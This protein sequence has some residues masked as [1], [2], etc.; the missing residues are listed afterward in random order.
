MK[1][2]NK[3]HM[4]RANNLIKHSWQIIHIQKPGFARKPQVAIFGMHM[5][6]Y[7]GTFLKTWHYYQFRMLHCM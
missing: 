2:T 6:L 7:K 3:F 4:E 1:A 5:M